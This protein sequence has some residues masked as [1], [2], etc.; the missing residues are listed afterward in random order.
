MNIQ[1]EVEGSDTVM[2]PGSGQDD[3]K[4]WASS[5]VL[6]WVGGELTRGGGVHSAFA[7]EL[8][9]KLIR[10]VCFFL[11][12]ANRVLAFFFLFVTFL[13][14]SRTLASGRFGWSMTV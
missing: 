7:V 11:D 8:A 6:A 1:K 4:D 10:L 2:F 13:Q 14:R 5:L 3:S 9:R 12:I